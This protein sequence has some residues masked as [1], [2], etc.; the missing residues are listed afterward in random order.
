MSRLEIGNLHIRGDSS[1]AI[2][3]AA[4]VGQLDLFR[5][6]GVVFRGGGV[7]R[8]VAVGV[9]PA[10]ACVVIVVEGNASVIALDQAPAGRVV[11][12]RGQRQAGIL[13]K[14]IDGL[15]QA[16]TESYLAHNESTIVILN[17]S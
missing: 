6:G 3:G 4:A 5:S 8:G 10:L 2:H 13:G 7:V 16:F 1:A 11:L 9:I 12:G 15:H 17:G 14:R